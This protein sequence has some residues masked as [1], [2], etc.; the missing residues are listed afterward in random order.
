MISEDALDTVDEDLDPNFDM[1]VSIK[2]D[3]E[4]TTDNFSKNWVTHLDQEDRTPLGV[5]LY[6][7]LKYIL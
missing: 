3:S 2:C 5:F 4:H 7:Q 1:D 6:F